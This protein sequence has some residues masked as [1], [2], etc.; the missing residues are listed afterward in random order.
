MGSRLLMVTPK[1]ELGI[2]RF[3]LENIITFIKE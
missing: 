2:T 3:E 1:I